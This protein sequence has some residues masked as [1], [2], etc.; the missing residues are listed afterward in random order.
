MTKHIYLQCLG[1]PALSLRPSGPLQLKTRK[2]LAVLV[3]VLRASGHTVSREQLADTFWGGAPREKAS[4][5]LRQALRQLKKL[6]DAAGVPFLETRSQ[7]ICV[8]PAAFR[9]DI[10]EI[11]ELVEAGGKADFESAR[12]LWT[13]EYL[14]NYD[15]LDPNFADWLILER[16]RLT[17]NIFAKAMRQIETGD[18]GPEAVEAGAQ[19]LLSMD[20]ALEAAH[21]LLIR[22][23][24]KTG[25]RELALA[26]YRTCERELRALLDAEPEPETRALLDAGQPRALVKS[27]PA[28][29][30][31]EKRKPAPRPPLVGEDAVSSGRPAGERMPLPHVT[32]ASVSLSPGAGQSARSLRDEVVAGL[33]AARTYDLFQADFEDDTGVN[34]LARVD[35][36][37]AG[38]Y[39]LRVRHDEQQKCIYLQLEDRISG[40]ILFHDIFSDDALMRKGE[41]RVSAAQSI[42]RVQAY[43]LDSIRMSGKSNPYAMWSEVQ[44]LFWEFTAEAE[45]RAM[46]I[47]DELERRCSSF[48][49]T[50]AAKASSHMKHRFLFPSKISTPIVNMSEILGLAEKAVKLDPWQPLNQRMLG[51]ALV[52]CGYA[53]EAQNAFL[54]AGRLS[55]LDPENLLSVGE[56]LAVSGDQDGANRYAEEALGFR[57]SLPRVFYEYMSNI[58]FS[59]GEYDEAISYV[60]R[61]PHSTL[62]GV[63]T[64]IASLL[65]C[66]REAEAEEVFGMY[67]ARFREVFRNKEFF[68]GADVPWDERICFFQGAKARAEFAAAAA[69]VRRNLD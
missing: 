41:L 60:E 64:R 53:R 42:R 32:V 51:W 3:Y 18:H 14:A 5:S 6:E 11:C 19:F 35:D 47:L 39:M 65:G 68:D 63:V 59:A 17:S 56:G 43:I 28:P 12:R 7:Y 67:R 10:D 45:H 24:L 36:N 38:S 58:H 46:R 62:I 48:S 8:D 15:G 13:G 57:S 27:G 61:A 21:R 66:G 26:Q 4:Q 44:G 2:S 23:F 54:E 37:G 40:R 52:Q 16:E 29:V 31:G 20:P 33:S 1:T 30:A 55:P 50:Y 34:A 69:F 49:Q 9:L 25:R 22:H